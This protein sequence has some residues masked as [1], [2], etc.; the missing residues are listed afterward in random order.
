MFLQ[1]KSK[2]IPGPLI[3]LSAELEISK[4]YSNDHSTKGDKG[5]HTIICQDNKW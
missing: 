1:F 3:V 4:I 2:N 5:A